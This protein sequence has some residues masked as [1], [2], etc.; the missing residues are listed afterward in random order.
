MT[1]VCGRLSL[2]SVDQLAQ[3]AASLRRVN[4]I[5]RAAA[6]ALLVLSISLSACGGGSSDEDKIK[7]IVKDGNNDPTTVCDNAS[8]ALLKQLGGTDACKKA[9]KDDPGKDDPADVQSVKITGDKAVASVKLKAGPQTINFVKEDG[10]W[11]VSG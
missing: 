7:S 2:G 5:R 1:G 11:K 9:A 4:T 10:D 3:R 8:K 6:P